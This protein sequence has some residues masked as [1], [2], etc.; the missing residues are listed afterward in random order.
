MSAA[1]LAL[2]DSTT[3]LRRNLRRTMRYPVG[4]MS[5]VA[6]PVVLLLLFVGVFGETMGAGLGS[7]VASGGTAG[8]ASGLSGRGEYLAYITP[9]ILLI[10]VA[11]ASQGVAIAV[12]IDMTE[13]IVARFRTMPIARGSVLTG[14]V[15][16][17][18]IETMIAL[19]VVLGLAVALGFRPSASLGAWVAVA[20][21][22]ALV[23][24]AVIWVAVA[25]GLVTESVE[26]ASNL[27]MPLLLLPFFG[28]GFVPTDSMPI[29]LRWFAEYQPF[30][31]WI[32]TVRGLL[33]GSS[34]G[35]YGWAAVAWAVAI[36]IGGWFW[37]RR[38]WERASA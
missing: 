20:G 25:M 22:L 36:G 34:I 23:T 11:G 31:A 19:V 21:L 16:S 37:S 15:L 18:L 29:G 28:S 9:A 6:V 2:K 3:M 13:G 1:A 26:T 12:A 35:W 8:A 38:L 5:T 14:H 32:E 4:P 7:T 10:S 24:L 17:N 33:S 27:P 30:T